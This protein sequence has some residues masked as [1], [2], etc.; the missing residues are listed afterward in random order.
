MEE[1][2]TGNPSHLEAVPSSPESETHALND[3]AEYEH[4]RST[5]DP[6]TER[7]LLRKMDLH[8]LPV[9]TLLYLVSFVDRANIGNARLQNLER[10]LHLSPQQ[11]NWALTVF[12]FPYAF[13]E[14]PSNLALKLLRPSVWL[15]LIMFLWGVTMMCMGWAQNYGGLVAA[16]FFLGVTEAGLFPGATY[17]CTTF[18]RRHEVQYRVSLF[19]CAATIAGAFSGLLAFAIGKMEGIRGYSGWRYVVKIQL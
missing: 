19:Y 4:L 9:L 3:K 12:F 16:R 2:S 11:Y 6:K 17:L 15:P 1:K 7:A 13:F 14:V 18:Y 10:D 8:I 5:F